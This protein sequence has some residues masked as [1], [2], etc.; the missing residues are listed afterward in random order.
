MRD[1]QVQRYARHV[2][3]PDV[4]GLGQTALMVAS[5]RL[6]L[7]ESEPV[8]ELI[9]GSYLAAGGVGTLVVP[10]ATDAQRAELAAHGPDTRVLADGG[11]REV[12]LA[13]KP[14]WW[15]AADG[16][17]TALAFWRG[18]IAATRWMTETIEK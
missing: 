5:A 2:I 17:A 16:D 10:T 6:P 13:P 4:G 15:P 9:A 7:R 3:L 14:A 1:D 11:G 18:A 12:V 8:A